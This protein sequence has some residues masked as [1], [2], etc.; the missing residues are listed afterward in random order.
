MLLL[1]SGM[2]LS[3][4]PKPCLFCE[5]F[6]PSKLFCFDLA[7]WREVWNLL[8]LVP[9]LAGWLAGWLAASPASP[10]SLEPRVL[11]RVGLGSVQL[12]LG[13]GLQAKPHPKSP[14]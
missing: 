8:G 9:W 14:P 5:S 7:F 13:S 11:M 12:H 1:N 3:A 2:E 4:L 10:A 6:E